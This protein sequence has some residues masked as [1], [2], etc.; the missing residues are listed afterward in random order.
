VCVQSDRAR[1]SIHRFVSYAT[2]LCPNVLSTACAVLVLMFGLTLPAFAQGAT[3]GSLH[4][5]GEG[6]I[7]D[8]EDDLANI[9]HT[10]DY[11]AFLPERVDLSD[12]FPK[13]GD[14]GDQ[15][16][17]VG[18]SVGYA[19][20][21]YYAN[22]VD[23]RDVGDPANIPSPSYIY[24]SIRQASQQCGLGSKISDAL[25][26]LERGALSLKQFP[27][28]D[29]NC[30][31][32]SNVV[33]SQASDF[34]IENW[35][36]VDARRIDQ[37]KG[38]LAYG[39]PVIVSLRTTEAFVQLKRG[40]IYRYPDQFVGYHAA[41]LVGYD[42]RRQAFKLINSWGQDWADGG[43]GWI[44]YATL[45]EEARGAYLMRVAVAPRPEPSPPP[46]PVVRP[47]QPPKPKQVPTVAPSPEAPTVKP[48]PV[49]IPVPTKDPTPIPIL[50]PSPIG[51]THSITL[52]ELEC[53]Q[54][55]ALDQG[56]RRTIVGFVG[57]DD[58]LS[59]VRAA[60]KGADVAVVVR[61]WPQ[62]EALLTLDKPLSRSDRPR[63]I[64]RRSSGDTLASGEAL[65][66]EVETPPFPSYLHMA[67]IQADGT[68]LNLVQPGVG[69]LNAYP[70]RSKIVIGD[71]HSGGP[72]FKVSAPYG[73]E[74]LIVLAGRSPIFSDLRS[75]Q[76][77]ER[78]FLT[79]LRRALIAKPDPASQD[80]DVTAG[81]DTIVTVERSVQ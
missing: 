35:F 10:P 8:N 47:T 5:R 43:F 81:F 57:K 59:A 17:C 14:Q 73:R 31:R 61:P 77:T 52:T 48:S 70:P 64:I 30:L 16:S 72:Q 21:A 71:G 79:A 55:R 75:T 50:P 18:W 33:R 54:L 65:V 3:D 7:L 9:P 22:R 27:Y 34:R 13:P 66:L 40:Q 1:L 56:G 45:R 67:Y 32:P 74:M 2:A 80:R 39:H 26:L 37:I 68:V 76:E 11:R 51:P 49:V 20:R 12:R 6:L 42:E 44:D 24:N 53:S 29:D 58:D 60:A 23:G 28:S 41:T 4:K 25:N 69:S 19:A 36:L 63:V 62:C 38:A 78:E 15:N 46:A